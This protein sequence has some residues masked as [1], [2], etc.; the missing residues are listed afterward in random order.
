MLREYFSDM[1]KQVRQQEDIILYGNLLTIDQ[2]ESIETVEF[3]RHEYEREALE[4]PFC[5][6][7]F[8]E[9]A[10]L[11]AAK[12]L[13]ISAQLILYRENRYTELSVLFH[14]FDGETNP[15]TIL[16]A[17]LC[18]RFIPDM[19]TQLKLI[20]SE[21]ELILILEALLYLW[22]Y[23]GVC[24]SL[25]TNQLN[26]EAITLNKC[27]H[28]LYINRIIEHKK[29]HLATLSVFKEHVASNLGMYSEVLWKDFKQEILI[30][31]KN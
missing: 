26:F 11:W 23:S 28:Q 30:N 15:S 21:D 12:T 10:A 8:D 5:A 19:L 4:Y 17:D 1:I 29:L 3:L 9:E 16:S 25:N 7:P 14:K 27:V 31:G 20:D 18:L 22:H 13:Y 24:Y 6:P 2:L